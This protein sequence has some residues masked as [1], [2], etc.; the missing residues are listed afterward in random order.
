[1][2]EPAVGED[3]GLTEG[4]RVERTEEAGPE[5]GK[6]RVEGG[7]EGGG[8]ERRGTG[9][10]EED[11]KGGEDTGHDAGEAVDERG[12]LCSSVHVEFDRLKEGGGGEVAKEGGVARLLRGW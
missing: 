5:V 11:G 6:G 2:D 4:G 7:R 8:G 10:V 12:E 1:L 3:E 9:R